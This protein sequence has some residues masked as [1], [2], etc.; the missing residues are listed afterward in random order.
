MKFSSAAILA[1]ANGIAAMPW[2]SQSAKHEVSN[3]NEDI[4]LHI[5]VS[6][7]SMGHGAAV[8]GAIQPSTFD[9]CLRV[10]W[11]ETP[12]CPDGWYS[13]NMGTTDDPCWTCCKAPSNIDL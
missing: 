13:N 8:H 6:Q 5:K 10:C 4:T 2:T 11:P 3:T 12:T 1:L 9:I 7:N